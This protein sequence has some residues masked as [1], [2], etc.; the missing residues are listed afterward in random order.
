[1]NGDSS[2]ENPYR[3][4]NVDDLDQVRDDLDAHYELV[5]HIDASETQKW[6]D[7]A[8]FDPIGTGEIT[9]DRRG[10]HD[11]PFTGVFDGNEYG[12]HG[13]HINRPEE[14]FVG[15]YATTRNAEI[16]DLTLQ[17]ADIHAKR[18]VGGVV[19][20]HHGELG[21][22][23]VTGDVTAEVDHCGGVVGINYGKVCDSTMTGDITGKQECGGIAGSNNGVISNSATDVTITGKSSIGGVAGVQREG[24]IHECSVACT[25]PNG[26]DNVGGV[27]GWSIDSVIR[28]SSTSG[29]IYGVSY[30]GGITGTTTDTEIN[31][32]IT[33]TDIAGREHIGGV[34]G[35][36]RGD[37]KIQDTSSHGEIEATAK[38]VGGIAAKN[39]GEITT[40]YTTSP[41]IGN[42]ITG[43]L[44][45]TNNGEI[46]DCYAVNSVSGIKPVGGAI[47]HNR[48]D[49]HEC[50]IVGEP[51]VQEPESSFLG[52]VISYIKK[53][54]SGNE[55]VFSGSGNTTGLYVVGSVTDPENETGLVLLSK[56]ESRGETARDTMDEFDFETVWDTVDGEYP[57]LQSLAVDSQLQHRK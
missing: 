37:S 50:Y 39:E 52:S 28:N 19:G 15:L 38:S 5:Q 32:S 31:S 56:N 10:N 24:E 29:D 23:S 1:M 46:S 51:I 44:L 42:K 2:Q 36:N 54:E 43:G 25:I 11:E 47:A 34:V 13:L 33:Q 40:S 48:G 3:I 6:G 41:V 7:G 27:V 17:D 18:L 55:V 35:A 22:V 8:G 53:T 21:T 49:V 16:R 4:A 30:I 14:L 12:I 45:A 9:G 26:G 20:E 57:V